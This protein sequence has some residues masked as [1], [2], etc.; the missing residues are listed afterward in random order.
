MGRPPT[1]QTPGKSFR[2]PVPLWDEVMKYA[3]AEGRPYGDVIIE[4][5]HD[6]LKKKRREKAPEGDKSG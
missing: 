6:W 4:A 5:L 2:P 3:E 1:G